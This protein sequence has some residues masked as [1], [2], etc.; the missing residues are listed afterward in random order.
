MLWIKKVDGCVP[1][2]LRNYKWVMFQKWNWM[3]V[4]M[5]FT[6]LVLQNFGRAMWQIKVCAKFFGKKCFHGFGMFPK[7]VFSCFWHVY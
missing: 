4:V 1:N 5:S 7:N 3:G 2:F 6:I